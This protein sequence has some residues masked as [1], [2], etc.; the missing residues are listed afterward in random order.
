[1]DVIFC[2][3][4]MPGMM[5]LFPLG[6]WISWHAGY[7]LAYILWLYGVWLLGRFAL[8]P[9]L[10]KGWKGPVTVGGILFLVGVVTFV[11]GLTQVDFPRDPSALGKLAPHIRAMWVL[12]L[13]VLSYA[14]PVGV[15]QA[16]LREL[17]AE[18]ETEQALEH[19]REALEQRR[20][21]E[22]VAGA[23]IQVK[24]GYQT[25]HIPLSAIRYVEGRNN[26]A[27]FHLDHR[28]DVVTQLS[29]K[30][31]LEQLPEGKFARIHR[32]YIV[33]LWRIE[34]SSATEVKLMGVEEALPVGR[35]HK[36]NLKNG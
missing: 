23:E 11:M 36:D 28:E 29:L 10:L 9:L 1:M 12:L 15:L 6:E 25:V 13:A 34:R 26:Y 14:L 7:V 35:A 4:V 20:A 27:C 3:V 30:A 21:A 18:K 8:G 17:S 33:P 19:A 2:I 16:R 32:S 22:A 31:V 24:A 5:F